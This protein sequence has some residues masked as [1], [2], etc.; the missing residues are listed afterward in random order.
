[1]IRLAY[2]CGEYPRA[3]DTFI[4]R[5]VA[6]LRKAGLRIETISVRRPQPQEQ[7]TEEQ[8]KERQ[9]T[10]YLLPCSPWRLLSVHLKLFF[11]SPG[12]Y[13][14]GLWLALTVRSP[15]LRSLL[16]QVFYFAESGLVASRMKQLGVTHVHNHAPD[17]SGYVAMLAAAIG[18]LTYSMTLHGFGILS[19][20]SKWRLKEKIE[21]SLFTICVSH[22]A[23]SQAMLWSNRESWNRL[24]VVHC[25]IEPEK[26]KLR[27]HSGSGRNILFVGRLDHVKG[28]PLLFEAFSVLIP[29]DPALHLHIV[30]DGPQRQDLQSMAI[31]KQLMN[32]ITFHG[33]K[34]Q[35]ELR[36]LFQKADVFVMSSFAEG[37]PV[38]LMEAMAF[39]TPVVAP[40]ITGIPELIDDGVNGLLTIPGNIESLVSCI[41]TLL[42]DASLRNR[43]ATNG[44]SKVDMDFNLLTETNRLATIMHD[45]IR[46]QQ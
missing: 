24:H 44:R 22:H 17:S 1:M 2:I 30:G 38:V 4:Q 43:F 41:E 40:R 20:P 7:G 18:D 14:R 28:L 10:F 31:K 13:F 25:G 37:I 19:E 8:L 16:Y 21:R 5:E 32:H 33:Y 36:E 35:T 12:R 42:K 27:Q 9:R 15:G 23:L 6:S 3:T 45:R 11:N 46:D 26:T 34:S 29:D 39:G